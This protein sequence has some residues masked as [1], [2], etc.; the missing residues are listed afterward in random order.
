MFFDLLPLLGDS[1]W[2][3]CGGV[4]INP[5]T[6]DSGGWQSQPGPHSEFQDNQDIERLFVSKQN[7]TTKLPQCQYNVYSITFSPLH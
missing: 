7:K 6:Q 2:A 1:G 5:S 4:H 3:V